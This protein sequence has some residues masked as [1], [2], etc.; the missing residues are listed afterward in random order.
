MCPSSASTYNL[1]K[2]PLPSDKSIHTLAEPCENQGKSNLACELPTT[3]EDV[4][5][6]QLAIKFGP[7][8]EHVCVILDESQVS[9]D[10]DRVDHVNYD[11]NKLN[12]SDPSSIP[13]DKDPIVFF[14]HKNDYVFTFSLKLDSCPFESELKCS[15]YSLWIDPSLF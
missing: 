7:L 15:N 13:L 3:N 5:N 12:R 8:L 2:V 6:D 1:N 11:I 14:V 4:C 10:V 9:N